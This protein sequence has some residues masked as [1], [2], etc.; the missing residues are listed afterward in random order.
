MR[1]L[2]ALTFALVPLAAC[3][4]PELLVGAASIDITPTEYEVFRDCGRDDLCEGDE[5]WTARDEGE[6]NH[7][8]DAF[9]RF[10]DC[11]VDRLC[12]GAPGYPGPDFGEGDGVFQEI[13]LAGFGGSPVDPH[14]GRPMLGAHDALEFNVL[15]LRQGDETFVLI[16]GDTV[17]FFHRVTNAIRRELRDDP[18][19][20]LDP[21]RVVVAA[22]H[23]HNGPDTMGIWSYHRDDRYL[24]KLVADAKAAVKEAVA[25]M[26]PARMYATHVTLPSCRDVE[27]GEVKTLENCREPVAESVLFAGPDVPILQADLRDPIVRDQQLGAVRFEAKDGSGT[28]TTFVNWSSHPE[29]LADDNN[30]A[31]TDFVGYVRKYVK[32]K[33][34]GHAL[35][36]SGPVGGMM[37]PL[38]GTESPRWNLDMTRADGWIGK[39]SFE[40]LWSLGY[41]VGEAAVNALAEAVADERPVLKVATR[42][43]TVKIENLQYNLA[44]GEFLGPYF[45][46]EDNTYDESSSTVEVPVTLV[47]LGSVSIVTMPG[48][49]LPEFWVG[50]EAITVDYA[51]RN[52]PAYPFP[53]IPGMRARM[54]GEHR[55]LIGLANNE[56]GYLVPE[57]DYL[58]DDNPH[59]GGRKAEDHPNYYEESV[60]PGK[61]AGTV[62]CNVALELAGVKEDCFG[63]PLTD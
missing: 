6:G 15:A 26:K 63:H 56:L 57:P 59:L 41:T 3:S 49:L 54:P 21:A 37:S 20:R 44:F 43:V 28:I 23:T 17:G 61:K 4:E 30:L 48:E 45:D 25:S 51:L 12:P 33:L 52:Y 19:L 11:G 46:P 13:R 47:T 38:R 8:F 32:A 53:A 50:R 9:E 35:Y 34:G 58:D 14:G 62:L 2:V 10:E 55:F 39:A 1:R 18:D 36:A 16:Q 5:G 27:T 7:E 29:A 60:S 31:S 22:T 42:D 24:T 40:K